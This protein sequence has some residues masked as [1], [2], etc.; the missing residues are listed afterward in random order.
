M[1][2]LYNPKELQRPVAPEE[3]GRRLQIRE[4]TMLGQKTHVIV[5]G[6]AIH[7]VLRELIK[8]HP[9]EVFIH[10]RLYSEKKV[11]R[12]RLD[13]VGWPFLLKHLEGVESPLLDDY[14]SKRRQ[15]EAERNLRRKGKL[16]VTK[17]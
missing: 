1:S 9:L 4:H 10:V 3:E 2:K 14:W 12:I 17:K 7:G 13:S 5:Q 8:E 15:K 11:R 6:K 16:R